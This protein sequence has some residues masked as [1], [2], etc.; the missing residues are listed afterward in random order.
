MGQILQQLPRENRSSLELL[1]LVTVQQCRMLNKA[2]EARFRAEGFSTPHT[3]GPNRDLCYLCSRTAST[4]RILRKFIK[5]R[6]P[7]HRQVDWG[8]HQGFMANEPGN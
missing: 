4:L 6:P 2:R 5:R 3:M 7:V 1:I 8:R